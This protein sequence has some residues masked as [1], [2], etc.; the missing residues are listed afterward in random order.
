ML[1]N[2][3]SHT[4]E[5]SDVVRVCVDTQ[6]WSLYFWSDGPARL[7]FGSNGDDCAEAPRGAFEMSAVLKIVTPGLTETMP[8][9]A[10]S[11]TVWHTGE[12]SVTAKYSQNLDAIR[13]LFR[14]FL[15]KAGAFNPMRFNRLLKEM[16]ILGIQD[17]TL[18][19]LELKGSGA[20]VEPGKGYALAP[21]GKG[22]SAAETKT[23]EASQGVEQN[24]ARVQQPHPS[25]LAST[26]QTAKEAVPSWAWWTTLPITLGI[27]FLLKQALKRKKHA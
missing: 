16:P 15:A 8:D 7:T 3:P 9:G 13:G 6:A 21:K 27:L 2:V 20:Y 23:V 22:A 17:I 10:V 14:D 5:D 18:P 4:A 24:G 26:A 25:Q 11:V 1:L 12:N 19:Q